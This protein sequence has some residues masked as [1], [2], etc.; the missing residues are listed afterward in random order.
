MLCHQGKLVTSNNGA[1]SSVS[2]G[3]ASELLSTDPPSYSSHI[4]NNNLHGS[5]SPPLIVITPVERSQRSRGGRCSEP[6]SDYADCFEDTAMDC[7]GSITNCSSTNNYRLCGGRSYTPPPVFRD[8][9]GRV[10]RRRAYENRRSEAVEDVTLVGVE[11]GIVGQQRDEVRS[12]KHYSTGGRQ[13]YNLLTG[14]MCW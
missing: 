4:R 5:L 3:G 11:D 2:P 10:S 6:L 13:V 7:N 12:H 8:Q 1:R 14:Y 9:N